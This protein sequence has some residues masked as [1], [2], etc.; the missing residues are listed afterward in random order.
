[1]EIN[2]HSILTLTMLAVFIVLAIRIALAQKIFTW[3]ST[4]NFIASACLIIGALGIFGS[5][6]TAYTRGSFSKSFEWPIG[7]VNYA[8]ELSDGTIVI[9]LKPTGRIQVYDPAL[10]F[11]RGWHIDAGGG[12]FKLVPA[13]D[14]SFYVYTARNAMKYL[15][16][17]N[18]V[19]QSSEEYS[20][21]YA[22]VISQTIQ[23][24]IPTPFY[25]LI[26][27]KPTYSW[28]VGLMGLLLLFITG[29]AFTKKT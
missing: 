25:L 1:M 17:T 21:S 24:S 27:T 19:L 12:T 23:V 5:D 11:Q 29:E 20:G 9:P 14:S 28:I 2:F 16:D 4:L 10:E 26:F 22:D 15:Y 8:I 18:G 7:N 13:D 3:K 6:L